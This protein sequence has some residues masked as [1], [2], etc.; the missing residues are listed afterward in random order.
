MVEQQVA[1]EKEQGSV[2]RGISRFIVFVIIIALIAALAYG[3]WWLIKKALA[4]GWI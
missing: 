4:E 3:G 1:V 2:M